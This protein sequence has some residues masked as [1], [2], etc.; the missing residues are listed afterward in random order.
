MKLGKPLSEQVLG[1]V[2]LP[3]IVSSVPDVIRV[4]GS[5]MDTK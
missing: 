4:G 5:R 1:S 3:L 2:E